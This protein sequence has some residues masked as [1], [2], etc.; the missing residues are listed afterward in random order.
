[1]GN[2]KVKK[3]YRSGIFLILLYVLVHGFIRLIFNDSIQVDDR[4]QLWYAQTLRLGY[5]MPQPPLYSWLGYLFFK[6]FGVG[7]TALTI[8]KYSIILLT[9]LY[10]DKIAKQIYA[11]EWIKANLIYFFLLMP[12]FAWHMHQGF[13]HTI[14]LGLGIVMSIFYFLKIEEKQSIKNYSLLGLSL[15]IGLLGKYSFV[16]FIL[17]FLISILSIKD[18][19]V[20]FASRKALFIPLII[21][22]LIS[23]HLFW[24]IDHW[25]QIY[26]QATT[27][28]QIGEITNSSFETI[29]KLFKSSIGFITPLFLIAF[30]IK[31]TTKTMLEDRTKKKNSELLF[32]RFLIFL[33]IFIVVF[34]IFF[35]IKQVKV[36]WLHPALM[37]FP[38]WFAFYLERRN[39][40]AK[41]SQRIFS[42]LVLFLTLLI[43]TL[44]VAQNTIGPSLGYYGRLNSPISSSLNSIPKNIVDSASIIKTNDFNLGVHLFELFPEKI[45]QIHGKKFNI[46]NASSGK[47]LYVFDQ[48]G[49]SDSSLQ[50]NQDKFGHFDIIESKEAGHTYR[51]FYKVL[52]NEKC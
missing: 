20:L 52:A 12:S 35:E 40:F 30:F 5:P 36:R 9:F 8:L 18:Y 15:S 22:I 37:V 33:T 45:I 14:L 29:F 42:Y 49:Y 3:F 34:A 51:L 6:I 27:R 32:N 50:K 43:F 11:S 31:R 39:A 4:E 48:D 2:H 17:L 7:L 28:L 47:C 26:S 21:F 16:L 19:R 46:D 41:N 38:F 44:R 23:P 1:M 25:S 13:T 24:L 10:V